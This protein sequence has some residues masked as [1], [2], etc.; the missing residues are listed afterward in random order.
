MA[1][2]IS[3]NG[4]ALSSAVLSIIDMADNLKTKA[5]RDP[6]AKTEVIDGK[7]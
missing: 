6:F 1:K 2:N 3:K 4:S 7:Q 5:M